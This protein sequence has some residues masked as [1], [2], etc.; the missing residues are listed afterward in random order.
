M[1]SQHIICAYLDNVIL[2]YYFWSEL[3]RVLH[4]PEIYSRANQSIRR[5]TRLKKKCFLW[6]PAETWIKISTDWYDSQGDAKVF[7]LQTSMWSA[8]QTF[9]SSE[10]R[11]ISTAWKQLPTEGRKLRGFFNELHCVYFNWTYL[12][13]YYTWEKPIETCTTQRNSQNEIWSI[14]RWQANL[15]TVTKSV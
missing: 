3:E 6:I 8:R 12:F 10:D 13:V 9:E 15:N 4:N 5:S 11:W 1:C 7:V 2:I 14:V